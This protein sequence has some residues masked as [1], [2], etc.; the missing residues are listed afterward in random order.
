[1]SNEITATVG[2]QRDVLALA[3][4]LSKNHPS[5]PV[6]YFTVHSYFT[7]TLG[8]QVEHSA[9]EAWREALGLGTE[10][11]DLRVLESGAYLRAAGKSQ[12]VQVELTGMGLSK[13]A[14][15]PAPMVVAA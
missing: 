8:I 1:M 5:L 12:D 3:Y 9:F 4:W 2:E 13:L 6:P 15:R 7:T 11:V 14:A 10:V